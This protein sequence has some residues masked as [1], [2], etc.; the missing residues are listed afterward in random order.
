MLSDRQQNIL[1]YLERRYLENPGIVNA[2]HFDIMDEL[3]I[4][5]TNTINHHLRR[6]EDEGKIKR[7]EGQ[8]GIV[9][10]DPP[11]LACPHCDGLFAIMD[12]N[13][14]PA[15]AAKNDSEGKAA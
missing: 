11:A 15:P 5:S 14:K 10:L 2:T 7:F 9:L 3:D 6:L 1:A 13:V 12:G 8:V 4:K